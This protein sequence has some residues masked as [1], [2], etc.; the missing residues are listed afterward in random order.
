MAWIQLHTA[1]LPLRFLS[2]SFPLLFVTWQLF[3]ILTLTDQVNSFSRSCFY[4]LSQLCFIC[5]SLSLHAITTKCREWSTSL[6]ALRWILGMLYKLASLPPTLLGFNL[7]RDPKAAFQRLLIFQ[8]SSSLTSLAPNSERHMQLKNFSLTSNWLCETDSLGLQCVPE[9]FL[10]SGCLLTREGLLAIFHSRPHG[11][12][13]Y[14]LFYSPI[15]EPCLGWLNSMELSSPYHA[16]GITNPL[17]FPVIR[18]SC[19]LAH[20]HWYES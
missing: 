10:Y 6:S 17:T 4:H 13:T 19:L 2:S 7:L 15:E 1:D 5:T 8:D 9:V 16:S 11:C 3:R 20:M 18:P 14:A 12:S